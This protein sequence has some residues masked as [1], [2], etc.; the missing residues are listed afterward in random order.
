ML[1]PFCYLK[2][3]FR[4]CGL[5]QN[6]KFFLRAT[7]SGEVLNGQAPKIKH[8]SSLTEL[9]FCQARRNT[10]S[11]PTAYY[12]K[13]R[14]FQGTTKP[15]GILNG[16]APKTECISSL[17]ELKFCQ[18]RRNT[19]SKPTAYYRKSR[20]F[21]GATKPGGILNGQA[22]KPPSTPTHCPVMKE[23]LSEAK[24]KTALATSIGVPSR[25]SGVASASSPSV[26]SSK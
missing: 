1:R 22:P 8:R 26:C 25:Q 17:T 5:D 7:K 24:N 19:E 13:S 3:L 14:C 9:K 6:V 12:R 21:Q 16:Q 4:H 10:E 11:K 20:C 2:H 23:A 15:G 18:A